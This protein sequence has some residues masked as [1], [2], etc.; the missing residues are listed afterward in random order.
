M[1]KGLNIFRDCISG[2]EGSFILIGGA[3]C[4]L[5]F[6]TLPD[7]CLRLSRCQTPVFHCTQVRGWGG[8]SIKISTGERGP[9]PGFR[10]F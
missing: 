3:A 7:A 6:V 4:D 10:R 8:L 9:P 1:V 2:F 5:W